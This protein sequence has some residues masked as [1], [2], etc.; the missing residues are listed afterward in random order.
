MRPLTKLMDRSRSEEDPVYTLRR[1]TG[2]GDPCASFMQIYWQLKNPRRKFLYFAMIICCC[3]Q[4]RVLQTNWW[5]DREPKEK[6]FL[7]CDDDVLLQKDS[8]PSNK[9]MDMSRTKG[10]NISTLRWWS[11]ATDRCGSFQQVDG[12][13]ENRKRGCFY[14]AMMICWCKQMPVLHTNWWTGREPKETLFLLFDDELL[15]QTELS[16]L[17]KLNEFSISKRSVCFYIVVMICRWW[18]ISVL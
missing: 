7:L 8:S 2:A 10:E 18:W 14:F 11:V 9:L 16:P 6:I 12:Q 17:S 13:V 5:T 4:M 3:K 1:W 15:L